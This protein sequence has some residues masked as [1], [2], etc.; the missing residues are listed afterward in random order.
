MSPIPDS[1]APAEWLLRKWGQDKQLDAVVAKL[2]LLMKGGCAPRPK[3]Q[4][5]VNTQKQTFVIVEG[6]RVPDG[7]A[8]IRTRFLATRHS[9]RHSHWSH[10]RNF[11]A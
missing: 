9:A 1:M 3:P 5:Y 11:G 8:Q 4:W 10:I 2:S 7:I 6:R